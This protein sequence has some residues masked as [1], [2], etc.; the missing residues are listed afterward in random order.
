MGWSSTG[1]DFLRELG[2]AKDA[3]AFEILW[4]A[5]E[6]GLRVR[7]VPLMAATQDATLGHLLLEAF[8]A[9]HAN[10]DVQL[11]LNSS[12]VSVQPAALDLADT[13]RLA[14]LVRKAP[15]APAARMRAQWCLKQKQSPAAE[16]A[17]AIVLGELSVANADDAF[18]RIARQRVGQDKRIA[19]E[20]ANNLHATVT[21][22]ERNW[23]LAGRF[24]D[25]IPPD[26]QS[27]AIARLQTLAIERINHAG[28]ALGGNLRAR[29]ARDPS[30]IIRALEAGTLRNTEGPNGLVEAIAEI[31]SAPD[32]GRARAAALLRQPQAF[33]VIDGLTRRWDDGEWRVTLDGLMAYPS[34]KAPASVGTVLARAPRRFAATAMRIAARHPNGGAPQIIPSAAGLAVTAVNEVGASDDSI[35]QQAALIA[36]PSDDKDP[37]LAVTK[38]VLGDLK[39][40]HRGHLVAQAVALAILPVHLA[41]TML[42]PGDYGLAL[43]APPLEG[44]LLGDLAG[45]LHAAAPDHMS[46]VVRKRQQANFSVALAEGIAPMDPKAAFA[47][48]ADVY[49]SFSQADRD[50]LIN[51]LDSHGSWSEEAL[52]TAF[53]DDGDRM[54][55]TRRARALAIAGRALRP[56]SAAP[57]FLVGAVTASNTAVAEA[58]YA[59]VAAIGPVDP[60]VA[61]ALRAVASSKYAPGKAQAQAALSAL[62]KSY[63][64]SLEAHRGDRVMEQALLAALAATAEQEAIETLLDYLGPNAVD[65]YSTVKQTAAKGLA[66]AV[67]NIDSRYL[68]QMAALLD[69]DQREGDP[70]AREAIDEAFR[71]ASLGEDAALAGLYALVGFTPRHD[72]STLFGAEKDRLVRQ[73]GLW[74]RSQTMTVT[75]RP[76]AISHLDNMAMSIV[77]A[78]YLRFGSSDAMKAQIAADRPVN[79]P[80]GT[81]LNALIG[82]MEKAKGPLLALHHS[83]SEETEVAHPGTEPTEDTVVA[84]RKNFAVGGKLLLHLL[85]Q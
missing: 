65:D 43:L 59:A 48:A 81:I 37:V 34:M 13:T 68:E 45:A 71:R 22:N 30:N 61:R 49:R 66:E 63:R 77:R 4:R 33:G 57:A 41:P 32:R 21:K 76:N 64:E 5:D 62:A 53:A 23:H 1:N 7:I 28:D 75:L 31:E 78:A 58:A 20:V 85:D 42:D 10:Q 70:K 38:A 29:F 79:P 67:D 73:T 54:N 47:G 56:G 24:L 82:P 18:F 14:D 46:V 26:Q 39:P 3:M 40:E 74:H 52:I 35:A 11:A 6:P 36:W 19:D 16:L 84:A 72:P 17:R 50:V 55:S 83:R 60:E 8:L 12:A 2:Q 69:G 9:A 51:L 25:A 44:K 27:K 15:Q 80:Y